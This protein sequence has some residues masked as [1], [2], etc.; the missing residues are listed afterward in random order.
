MY[1]QVLEQLPTH[2]PQCEN[3]HNQPTENVG[4]N[5][6]PNSTVMKTGYNEDVQARYLSISAFRVNPS[7]YGVSKGRYKEERRW[8]QLV[9]G[10]MNGYRST[11]GVVVDV[12]YWHQG[13]ITVC[14]IW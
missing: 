5:T 9:D 2:N 4:K 3:N 12:V 11:R 7:L 8:C 1:V 14:T 13:I 10:W 6:N